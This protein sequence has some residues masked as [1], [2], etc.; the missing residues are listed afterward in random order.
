MAFGEFKS[1]SSQF[2]FSKISAK[3]YYVGVERL[4]GIDSSEKLMPLLC[5]A[6]PVEEKRVEFGKIIAI[7]EKIR[8]R[9]RAAA[10]AEEAKRAEERAAARAA[11]EAQ[12]QADAQRRTAEAEAKRAAEAEAAAKRAAAEQQRNEQAAED[13]LVAKRRAEA[14]AAV[15]A[16]D[17]ELQRQRQAQEAARRAEEEAAEHKLR[18][19]K[20]YSI[21][22][23]SKVSEVDN[24]FA[25]HGPAVWGKL[26]RK[27]GGTKHVDTVYQVTQGM[28]NVV[29]PPRPG[30]AGAADTAA[31][32]AP[33]VEEAK[34]ATVTPSTGNAIDPALE[35]HHHEGPRVR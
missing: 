22:N 1:L 17:A 9:R 12:A 11:A 18:L 5:A 34:A 2:R 29:L 21:V 13:P 15:A 19:R 8:A 14:E 31:A 7:A 6:L 3:D 30:T 25:K 27:Y 24:I 33:T 20:F 16:R 28:P 32:P 4:V 23:E 35:S 10:A 26:V